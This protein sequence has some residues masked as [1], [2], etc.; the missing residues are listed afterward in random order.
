MSGT[1]HRMHEPSSALGALT[2][3]QRRVAMS[4]NVCACAAS[5]VQTSRSVFMYRQHEGGTDRWLVDSN[6][7]IVA[8]ESFG[9]AGAPESSPPPPSGRFRRDVAVPEQSSPPRMG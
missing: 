6:G 9:T 8:F 4:L 5:R 2:A 1:N 3:A 7:Y